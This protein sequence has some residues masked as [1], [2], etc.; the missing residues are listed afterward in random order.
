MKQSLAAGGY[1]GM[2][3]VV[4]TAF[5]S[6][7]SVDWPSYN[8]TLTSERYAPLDAINTSTI[9]GLEILCTYDTKE[10]T[11]F[12]T[13]LVQVNGGLYGT[14]EHD[15]FS[16]NPDTCRQ[17]WH[18]HEEFHSGVLKVDRGVA[19]LDGKIF[20][21]TADGRVLAYD[22]ASGKRLWSTTIA[23]PKIG[24]SVPAAPIAWQGMVFIGNAGGDNKGV[25]GR[26]YGLDAA[27][28]KILWEFY[29]VPREASDVARGPA[30][31]SAPS[32]AACWKTAPGFPVTGGAT[33]TS[34]TLDPVSG[35]LYVPGGNPAPDFVADFR[36]GDNLYTG[37]VIVLD[38]RTGA[39]QRHFQLV[40]RDF[41]DWDISTAPSLFTVKG[42]QRIMAVAPKDGH[43]Y[44]FDLVT[45]QQLYRQ[46]MTTIENAEAPLLPQGTRFCPGT[47]GGAE[48]NGPA[49]DPKHNT[50]YTGE[51]DWCTTVHTDPKEAIQS[52]ALGQPWSAS[53][54]DHFGKQDDTSLWAGWLT[55]TD[56][57][58]GARKWRF[59]APYPVLSGVTPT[60]GDLVLFGDM[61]G[62]LYAFD[63]ESGKPLW[64]RNL[65]GAIAGGVV[66]YDTGAGQKIAVATGMTSPIWPTAKV[67]AKVMVLGLK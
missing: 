59:K 2:A 38:A 9:S 66:T 28:G 54:K 26:M 65:G 52:V 44:A 47:Q 22:A 16:I 56:A 8:R 32:E 18:V 40:Q 31:P 24:E 36:D 17:N 13:G 25:K 61:G 58:T 7:A 49:F 5:A 29:N 42:G 62:N 55:A 43:L 6:A 60:A 21:G 48:W 53:S 34:Y 23:N 35:L 20:R 14:T 12:Q 41:H 15:T 45:N 1:L 30:A 27:T 11:G 67:T 50:I 4:L 19:Y 64:S 63:S 46:P 3:A 10:I 37:S 39:Y 51:V 57:V 33:W